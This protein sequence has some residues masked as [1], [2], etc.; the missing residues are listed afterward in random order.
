M[1]PELLRIGPF[2]IRWY[3][4]LL[5]GGAVLAAYF[6][7][8]TAQR[9]GHDPEHVWDM[10]IWVL[11]TGIVGAR[12][13][14][15]FS[16]PAG[17]AVGWS[18]YR[19][20][21]VDILR[22]WNGGLAI[23]GALLGGAIGVASYVWYR[24]LPLIEWFDIVFPNVL[25]AQAIGRWGNFVNQEAYGAP[26]DLPWAIYID[27]AHRIQGFEQYSHFHPTFLYESI[28]CFLGWL[29]LSW[30]GRRYASRLRQGDLA[31]LYFV[32]YPAARFFIESLRIDAWTMGGLATAQWISLVSVLVATAFLVGRRLIPRSSP[33]GRPD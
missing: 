6:A 8:R 24:K 12:L 14:H 7:A 22:I 17:G 26:T 19:Q 31:A 27:P 28:W 4:V 9:R 15:V 2:A 3:G 21:P 32:W 1:N 13:Y 23:Y 33:S 5:I 10:L 29:V 20:H 30:V 25:L 18:Y 16:S 11:F